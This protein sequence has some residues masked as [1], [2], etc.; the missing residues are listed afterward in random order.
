MLLI[1]GAAFLAI[2]LGYGAWWFVYAR[3]FEKTDDAY[4]QGNLVQIT[5]Q[6]AGTVVSVNA[7]DTDFVKAG[8]T[9]VSLDR[10][11]AEVALDQAQAALGQTVREV[12]QLYTANSTWSANITQRQADIV[13]AQSDLA[14]TEDDLA[15]RTD[16]ASTG[17]VS[18][19]RADGAG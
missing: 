11:D 3:H 7:D 16:L 12:R 2:A 19:A 15:R 10:A 13:R 9:L 14:R 18:G 5:P 17:A 4:V 6:V 8:Q 1:A